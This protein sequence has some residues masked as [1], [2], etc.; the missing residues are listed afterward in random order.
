MYIITRNCF[1]DLIA[2]PLL[3]SLVNPVKMALYVSIYR[4]TRFP[5]S[6]GDKKKCCID[7]A[8]L[9]QLNGTVLYKHKR[10]GNLILISLWIRLKTKTMY[11]LWI[12]FLS[13]SELTTTKTMSN[14][15]VLYH[16]SVQTPAIV[17]HTHTHVQHFCG[18]IT[19]NY[20]SST[21][22]CSCSLRL[23]T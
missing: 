6:G 5:Y 7:L 2:T 11:G 1:F 12:Y 22:S 19:I 4:K 15:P 3:H 10:H 17:I 16:N 21:C 20:K 13:V 23:H 8:P 18:F 14:L 9:T